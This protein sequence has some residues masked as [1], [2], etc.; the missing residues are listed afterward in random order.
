MGCIHILIVGVKG[1]LIVEEQMGGF[2]WWEEYPTIHT[3]SRR[4]VGMIT[5]C[6]SWTTEDFDTFDEDGIV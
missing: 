2:V 4:W 5:R 6:R 3:I 1:S